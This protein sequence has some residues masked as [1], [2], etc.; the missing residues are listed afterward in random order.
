M[1]ILIAVV[2]L[3]MALCAANSVVRCALSA[4]DTPD[5]CRENDYGNPEDT[6][7]PLNPSN[8]G[9][10]PRVVDAAGKAI[11][12]PLKAGGAQLHY[13]NGQ[14]MRTPQG[15]VVRATCSVALNYGIRLDK[16]GRTYFMAWQTNSGDPA[17][18]PEK[19][20]TGWVLADDM[21]EEAA[22]TAKAVI[23]HRLGNLKRPLAGD[24]GGKPRTFVVNGN[25]EQAKAAQ[26]LEWVYI[27]ITGHHRDK[28]IN[29][30]N[31]HDGSAGL[32]MLVNLPNVHGGGI[33]SDCFPNGTSFIAAADT[34]NNLITVSIPVFDKEGAQHALTFIYG[35]AGE[36]WGWMVKEWLDER[37][38]SRAGDYTP[39][40]RP[41]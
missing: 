12:F 33:A 13:G 4:V 25:T 2:A 26:S 23:P 11:S 17:G 24:A 15:A 6:R 36:S 38:D 3:I 35:R 30:L 9:L 14:P 34:N 31:L 19:D 10:K 39:V 32:Q 1:R 37:P 18:D 27:G 22:K 21:T 16:E 5:P 29:F 40:E 20:A 7:D 41:K 28:V 8:K